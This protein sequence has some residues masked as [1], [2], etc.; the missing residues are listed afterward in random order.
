LPAGEGKIAKRCR[1]KKTAWP[2]RS[3]NVARF[4]RK[5]KNLAGR[6][7][8]ARGRMVRTLIGEEKG[9]ET[10]SFAHPRKKTAGILVRGLPGEKTRSGVGLETGKGERREGVGYEGKWPTRKKNKKR[11]KV[12]TRGGRG[13]KGVILGR[14]QG[15]G[16]TGGHG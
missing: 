15:G 16:T 9:F 1:T 4:G 13:N 11:G 3:N 8:K 12:R 5:K 14:K 2:S 6:K 10:K 7:K